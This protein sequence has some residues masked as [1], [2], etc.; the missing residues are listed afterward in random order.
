MTENYFLICVTDDGGFEIID[1][2]DFADIKKIMDE[3]AIT[4]WR[5][6]LGG[7]AF[8][9]KEGDAMLIKG[10]VVVPKPKKTV[11]EWVVP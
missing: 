10:S 9:W 11:V 7:N 5:K 8:S 3:F 2:V 6:D 1:D 4:N